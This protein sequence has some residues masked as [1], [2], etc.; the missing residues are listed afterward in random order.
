MDA[1]AERRLKVLGIEVVLEPEGAA[2]RQAWSR[3]AGIAV[4]ITFAFF[5]LFFSIIGFAAGMFKAFAPLVAG[6]SGWIIPTV[7]APFAVALLFA[8]YVAACNVR[9]FATWRVENGRLTVRHGPLPLKR[10]RSWDAAEIEQLW[11]KEIQDK[12]SD[13]DPFTYYR[14]CLRTREGHEVSLVRKLDSLEQG[15]A[16]EKVLEERLDIKD[17]PVEG[18]TGRPPVA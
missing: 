9:N 3:S 18:E 13:G 12:D 2:V 14:L 7:L 15:R 4:F 8:L 1:D 10:G 6:P 17:R 5:A 11:V 16:L